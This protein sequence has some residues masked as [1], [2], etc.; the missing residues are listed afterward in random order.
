MKAKIEAIRA[1][2]AAGLTIRLSLDEANEILDHIT[3]K[4]PAPWDAIRA[5]GCDPH[6]HD[7]NLI[8]EP[9]TLPVGELGGFHV[10]Q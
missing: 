9:Q 1:A 3:P 2:L 4:T 10:P 6:Y 8:L 7:G 5:L